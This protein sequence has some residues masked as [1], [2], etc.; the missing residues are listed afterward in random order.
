MQ[1]PFS[2]RTIAVLAKAL[3]DGETNSTMGAL[4]LE[5]GADPWYGG[6]V[7]KLDKAARA[8]RAMR[9]DGSEPACKAALD[10][11]RLMLARGKAPDGY[12][13]SEPRPWW[14][15]LKDAIGVDGWE[16]DES[17]DDFVPVV[18]GASMVDESSWIAAEL[19]QRGWS[20][21]A[22]HYKQALESY[23]DGR[24]AAANGQLRT[25]FESTIRTAGGTD[26]AAGS[27]QVQRAFDNLE[28]SS[29]LLPGEADFG[30]KLWR[31][32][33]AGGSHPGLSDEDESRFRLLTLTGYIRFL[34]VR[35]PR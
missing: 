32:L 5:A 13:E 31:M 17:V 9:D 1:F 8:L 6:G 16:F 23:A 2:D 10:L 27:G 25:F 33:H 29:A 30:K 22:G 18:P 26:T 11:G 7:S 19:D 12:W 35:L 21:A 14:Q 24:W 3:N 34:L 15:P 4:F 28:R 20:V